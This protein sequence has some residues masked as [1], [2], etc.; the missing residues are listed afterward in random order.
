MAAA[1]PTAAAW[2]FLA[3]TLLALLAVAGWPL[4]RTLWLSFTDADLSSAGYH[5]VGV[6]NFL[7]R[8]PTGWYGV[9][10]DP[11]WWRT[12]VNTF[13]F[14]AI[15]VSLETVLGM[16][17]ALLLHAQFPGRAL[18]RTAV[19]VPWAIPTVVSAKLWGWIYHDQYG[20]LNDLLLR[21]GAIVQP[22]AWT[23]DPH[24]VMG[25]VIAAD[26]WKTTPF[27]SLLLLAGLQM[28]PRDCYDA[29]RLDGVHPIKVFLRVTLPL[30]RPVLVVTVLFRAL[31]ALRVF[32]LIYVLTPNNPVTASI[33]VYVRQQLVDFHDLGYGSAAASLVFFAA[34]LL[35]VGFLGLT[36]RRGSVAGP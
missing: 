27:V 36:R 1:R 35:T 2:L 4:G 24:L 20:L 18:A 14:V 16:L 28:L 13:V 17:I 29:A 5:L 3:P 21:A 26:V 11:Q 23:A 19:L 15:S 7:G 6:S 30:L 22:L 32:D 8:D 31:D 25:A 12:V 9:L 34:A 33:S 10:A